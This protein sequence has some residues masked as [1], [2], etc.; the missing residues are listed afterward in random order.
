M[1]ETQPRV[2]EEKPP[3]VTLTQPPDPL[4]TN[5]HRAIANSIASE[6]RHGWRKHKATRAI[7]N[8]RSRDYHTPG[9]IPAIEPTTEL[10]YNAPYAGAIVDENP[11]LDTPYLVWEV[12]QL[13]LAA[14]LNARGMMNYARDAQAWLTTRPKTGPPPTAY[15]TRPNRHGRLALRRNS[16]YTPDP[17]AMVFDVAVTA[18]T[19]LVPD[20]D[21]LLDF[22]AFFDGMNPTALMDALRD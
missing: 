14:A 1:T 18:A 2:E 17:V 6:L 16:A 20:R 22:L 11:Q 3:K 12:T 8:T 13:D 4:P 9:Q 15:I 5:W 7:G 19:I 10:L 21:E